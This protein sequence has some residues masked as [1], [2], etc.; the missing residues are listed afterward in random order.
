MTGPRPMQ[1]LLFLL[2]GDGVGSGACCNHGCRSQRK[3][4]DFYRLCGGGGGCV[5]YNTGGGGSGGGCV[6]DS[7]W[8]WRWQRRRLVD[9]SCIKRACVTMMWR[10]VVDCLQQAERL[11]L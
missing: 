1:P 4:C 10:H 3:M 2:L 9:V 6:V 5:D 11:V 7:G 8:W